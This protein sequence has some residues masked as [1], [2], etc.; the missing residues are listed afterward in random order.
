MQGEGSKSRVPRKSLR[1]NLRGYSFVL[2]EI[3]L[4]LSLMTII[5][6]LKADLHFGE[7]IEVAEVERPIVELEDIEAT[8][9]LKKPPPPPR[10]APPVMISDD[11]VLEEDILEIDAEIDIEAVLDVPPPPPAPP[12]RDETE[13]DI[14][15]VVEE[16]PV[17]IGGM[18]HL[19]SLVEYPEPAAKAGM[20]GLVIVKFV[21]ETDGSPASITVSKSA[22]GILDDAALRAVSQLKFIPGRQRGIPV[23]GALLA[24]RPLSIDRRARGLNA[25]QAT[26]CVRVPVRRTRNRSSAHP[27]SSRRRYPPCRG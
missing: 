14:F 16:M 8:E 25:L 15:V 12:T 7:G 20:E 26:T 11:E 22:G 10:P 6:A 19:R 23:R 18:A 9:H 4:I 27:S 2:T 13:P 3:G 21:V 17:L 1:F 24:T 5:G